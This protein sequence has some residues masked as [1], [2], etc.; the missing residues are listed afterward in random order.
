MRFK[1]FLNPSSGGA[2]GMP[3]PKNPAYYLESRMHRTLESEANLLGVVCTET[4]I[5]TAA[6]Y[7]VL[8]QDHWIFA[9]TGL[10]NGDLFGENCLQERINGGASGHETDKIS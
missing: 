4:G 7:K 8:K 10:K 1:T 9:G 6:P 3:D 2:L 5:M